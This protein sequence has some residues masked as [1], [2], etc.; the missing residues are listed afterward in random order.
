MRWP[1][2]LMCPTET[3][4]ARFCWNCQQSVRKVLGKHGQN[5]LC[6]WQRGVTFSKGD[7]NCNCAVSALLFPFPPQALLSHVWKMPPFRECDSE[8]QGLLR[9]PPDLKLL[10]GY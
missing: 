2:W 3:V 9:S 1:L 6:S 7:I 5:L 10:L 4:R 8:R